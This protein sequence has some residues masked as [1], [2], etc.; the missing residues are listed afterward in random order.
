M[1]P[2]PAHGILCP[3]KIAMGVGS[4]Y[5]FSGGRMQKNLLSLMVIFFAAG[6][7]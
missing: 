7:A 6:A 1:F 3:K 2:V 5:I 4:S